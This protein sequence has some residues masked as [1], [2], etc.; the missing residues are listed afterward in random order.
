V[1]GVPKNLRLKPF[2]GATL[3]DIDLLGNIVYFNFQR[4][5]GFARTLKS[6]E[7]QIGVEGIWE[8]RDHLGRVVSRGDPM[9][10][11]EADYPIGKVVTG[12]E[13]RH[14]KSFVLKFETGVHLEV[15]DSSREFESFS[16][17]QQGV[18][19]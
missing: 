17:P 7:L 4:P 10:A 18:Y 3:R 5:P 11:S 15:F 2:V 8:L 19:V 9:P 6:R 13:N 14:P 12:S 16:I 1:H